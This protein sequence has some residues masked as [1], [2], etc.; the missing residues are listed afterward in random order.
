MAKNDMVLLCSKRQPKIEIFKCRDLDITTNDAGEAV[1]TTTF[2]V[3][4]HVLSGEDG[5][6]L[7]LLSRGPAKKP[8]SSKILLSLKDIKICEIIVA[9]GKEYCV[10]ARKVAF[11][12]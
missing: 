3:V 10:V 1:L 9:S 8:K 7:I 5:Y 4:K 2:P 12:V 11:N 6:N